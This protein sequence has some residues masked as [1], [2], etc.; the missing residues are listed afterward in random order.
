MNCQFKFIRPEHDKKE[1]DTAEEVAGANARTLSTTKVGL[2]LA[3]TL[4]RLAELAVTWC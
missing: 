2:G 3:G 4:L 1:K